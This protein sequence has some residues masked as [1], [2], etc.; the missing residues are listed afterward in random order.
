MGDTDEAAGHF[1]G[2]A[3]LPLAV[4][5]SLAAVCEPARASPATLPPRGCARTPFHRRVRPHGKLCHDSPTSRP[6]GMSHGLVP[7]GHTH[8]QKSHVMM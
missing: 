4:T 8:A 3:R 7:H 1:L 6:T 2:H 5:L